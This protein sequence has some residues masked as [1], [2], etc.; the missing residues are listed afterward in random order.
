[1]SSHSSVAVDHQSLWQADDCLPAFPR[2]ATSVE[3]DVCIVGAG[4]AGLSVAYAL[5]KAGKNVVLVDD[6][7]VASGMSLMTTAHLS[8]AIDDRF[9]NIERWHGADGARL[10]AESHAAAIQSIED[11]V[12]EIGAD[13]DFRRVDGYLF[14]TPDDDDDALHQELDAA[15]RAGVDCSFVNRAPLGSAPTGRSLVFPQQA[16]IHAAKYYAALVAAIDHHGGKIFAKSHVDRI[17]NGE[18]ATVHVGKQSIRAAHVVVAT[19][20]PVNDT[21]VLHTKQAPYMTYVIAGKVPKEDVADALYWDTAKAY[22]YVRLQPSDDPAHPWLIVGGEDHKS[23]QADD[24]DERHQRLEVWAR[25][26]IPTL[27]P[28][29]FVWGGQCMETMDGLAFIGRNP[30][31]EPNI[32]VATGDS[33]MGITHGAIAGMLLSDLILGRENP[34]ERLY[35]PTRKSMRALGTFAKE[36]LNV[37]AQYADWLA[38][39]EVSSPDDIPS[40]SGA[41]LRRGLSRV[42]VYKSHE[43]KTTELSATCPHLGCVVHWNAA[44]RTWDCPCHGSR[45]RAEGEVINGPANVNLEAPE[46]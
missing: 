30:L 36:N 2:L 3:A 45:F 33:G 28:I 10:A 1:M 35:D 21:F 34:W 19:N 13:C 16:R 12:R 42:A 25:E 31:D 44:E 4:I 40:G 29:E 6:G 8:N 17:E 18:R 11:A 23:G 32:Y 39:A 20:S 26:R 9:V 37:A 46:S 41:V 27:G 43:G 5:T 24:A 7:P 22:H 14:C 38:P 15:R